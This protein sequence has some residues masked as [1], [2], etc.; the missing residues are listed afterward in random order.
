MHGERVKF[1][2]EWICEFLW[3]QCLSDSLVCV[4]CSCLRGITYYY[5]SIFQ[6]RTRSTSGY[7]IL[8]NENNGRRCVKAH[9]LS[10]STLL[11]CMINWGMWNLAHIQQCDIMWPSESESGVDRQFAA[12]FSWQFFIRSRVKP[13][14]TGIPYTILLSISVRFPFHGEFFK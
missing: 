4:R 10:V 11:L 9:V 2:K 5:Y 3:T 8:K 1:F 12:S 14:H 7:C 13:A 6:T